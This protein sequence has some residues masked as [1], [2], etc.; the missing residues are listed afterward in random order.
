MVSK[1]AAY[2]SAFVPVKV[3]VLSHTLSS[4]GQY[5]VRW[6]TFWS[7]GQ[8]RCWYSITLLYWLIHR[9]RLLLTA[10]TCKWQ[11]L[12]LHVNSCGTAYHRDKHSYWYL[13][14]GRPHL[15]VLLTCRLAISAITIIVLYA[16][17]PVSRTRFTQWSIIWL[18]HLIY[19][20]KYIICICTF[21]WFFTVC[22]TVD[23]S[24]NRTEIIGKL[25][26]THSTMCQQKRWQM[27]QVLEHSLSEPQ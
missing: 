27:W 25:W 11:T 26:A 4:Y 20:M 15:D 14:P 3:A 10:T 6:P 22:I 7:R 19:R 8:W 9:P 13:F 18:D 23:S 24:A 1:I 17:F 21:F 5:R 2:V 16:A 12:Q